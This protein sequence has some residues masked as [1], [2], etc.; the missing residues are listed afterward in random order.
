MISSPI[1][2]KQVGSAAAQL[3]KKH[4]LTESFALTGWD[5]TFEELKWIAEWQFVNGV[6]LI[7]QHLQ[8]YSIRGFRKRDY[9][10][11]LFIQQ[12]WWEKYSR[13]ND[14]ISRLGVLLTSGIED[15]DVLVIHPI[16]SAWV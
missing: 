3:G 7:C 16:R 8:G 5:V 2:P 9:P 4:V 10:P 15:V 1:V 11:S 14:Y 12:N 6:N 13:F